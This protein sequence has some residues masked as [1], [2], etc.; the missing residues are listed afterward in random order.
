MKLWR[1][2][3]TAIV[4]GA[5]CFGVSSVYAQ[6]KKGGQQG[7]P[8]RALQAADTDKDGQVSREEYLAFQ[9]KR[10]DQMDANGDG[11]IDAEEAANMNKAGKGKGKGAA[12]KERKP[13]A[14]DDEGD[15]EE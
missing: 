15:M 4:A 3:A 10:F 8:L 13:K 12:K 7:R 14:M 11:Y 6:G 1:I 9:E 2:T 5:L